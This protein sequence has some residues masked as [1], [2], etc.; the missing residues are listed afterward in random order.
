[1]HNF[2]TLEEIDSVLEFAKLGRDEIKSVTQSIYFSQ[3]LDN[4]GIKLLELEPA[5]LTALEN[6]GR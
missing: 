2:S 5:V 1:M 6:G 3:Q 4:E